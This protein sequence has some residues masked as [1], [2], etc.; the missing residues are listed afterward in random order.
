MFRRCH[1]Q[2][3]LL[4]SF[5]FIYQFFSR[6]S[7]SLSSFGGRFFPHS[8]PLQKESIEAYNI[9]QHKPQCAPLPCSEALQLCFC[10]G[11]FRGYLL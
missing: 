7:L 11:F 10:A 8:F 9:L 1:N 6:K 5:L 2:L 4:T 3:K